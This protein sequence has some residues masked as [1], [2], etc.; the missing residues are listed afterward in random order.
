[1]RQCIEWAVSVI[2]AVILLVAL[3][4]VLAWEMGKVIWE[5][6]LKGDK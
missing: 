1:M 2:A 5:Y 3:P 4:F 6:E